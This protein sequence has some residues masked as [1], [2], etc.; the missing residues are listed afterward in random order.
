[1]SE[2][3]QRN[4]WMLVY[5]LY[6]Y[7]SRVRREAESVAALQGHDVRVLCLKEEETP[8]TYE[9]QGVTVDELNVPKY[10]GKGAGRY[11]FSYL[12]FL[13]HGFLAV[14]RS[15]FRG[16][17]DIVHVHNMPNFIVFS[18]LL[19]KIFGKKIILDIHDTLIETYAAKFAGKDLKWKLLYSILRFE[20]YVSCWFAD[21]IIC[22]NEIQR[23]K[24]V[25]RGIKETK[26]TVI[27]NVPDSKYFD[28]KRTIVEK[29]EG[30]FRLVY[31]G[32]VAYRQG[33][34]LAIL[35]VNRIKENI[36]GLT[37]LVMGEGDDWRANIELVQELDAQESVFFKKAVPVEE[38]ASILEDAD[39]GIIPNRRSIASELMLPVKMLEY[40]ALGIPVVVPKLKTIQHYFTDE[41]V[42]YFDPDD[43]VALANAILSAYGDKEGR[44]AK[45]L[46]AKSFYEKFGWDLHK[47]RLLNLYRQPKK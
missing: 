28:Y 22:V 31:H 20:E 19:P 10:R 37:F 41:M 35:A 29:K 38:L 8:R 46:R 36:E 47:D 1:M 16:K 7:D 2:S 30:G 34:D 14:S 44:S 11:V 5:T 15:F 6:P 27:K 3:K 24:L 39:L 9:L 42:Y 45:A 25:D 18:A 12:V 13:G 32:T 43:D 40:V 23:Q 4:T 21:N 17:V 33:T 26:I